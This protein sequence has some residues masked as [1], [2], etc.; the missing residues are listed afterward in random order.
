MMEGYS[1]TIELRHLALAFAHS[2]AYGDII[3]ATLALLSLPRGAGV[4]TAWIQSLGLKPI[5]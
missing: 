5:C 1:L 4:V 2:A 3:S